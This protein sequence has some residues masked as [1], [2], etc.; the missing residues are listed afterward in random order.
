MV[1][2][3]RVFGCA[4]CHVYIHKVRGDKVVSVVVVV[5]FFL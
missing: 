1:A 5:V 3:W 2:M 4:L